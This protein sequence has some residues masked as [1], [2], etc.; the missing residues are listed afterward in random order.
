MTTAS[1]TKPFGVLAPGGVLDR[2]VEARAKRLEATKRRVPLNRLAGLKAR[3]TNSLAAALNRGDSTNIIAEIKHRSP[4]K[5][6]I[7]EDF[8]PVR[9]AESYA[10]GGAAAISVLCEEDFFG[11]SLEHLEAI[12]KRVEL[13]LLRKDFIFDEYQLY[14][15]ALAGADAVLLIVAILED[16]LLVKLIGL[17]NEL[18]LDA[19]VEVHSM[20]EMERAAQAGASI[21]GV[22]NRDLTTFKVDLDTSIQLG[23][24][25]PEGAILVSESGINTGS[26][27][28]RLRSA[29]FSAFL[30]GEHLLR[31]QHPGEALRQLVEEAK[32]V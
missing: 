32:N 13:P 11:G 12:R 8:D 15:S 6:I 28:R 29:G 17:A 7:R 14:E 22:N 2:I 26:D 21:V 23:P 16:E 27:I 9:I 25:A 18:G 19:L 24:L 30:V 20:D 3:N 4:S 5:G 31:A 1:T 10:S